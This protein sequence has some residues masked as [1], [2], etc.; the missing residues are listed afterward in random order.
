MTKLCFKVLL[1]KMPLTDIS[2]R[3]KGEKVLITEYLASVHV[4]SLLA[5]YIYNQLSKFQKRRQCK[6]FRIQVPVSL[7]RIYSSKTRRNSSLF[8]TP[9][10]V[11]SANPPR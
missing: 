1:A 9:E 6:M 5:I 8:V 2:A 10:I 3:S 4:Y 11:A 7:R